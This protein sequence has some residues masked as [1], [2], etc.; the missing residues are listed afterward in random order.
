M[1]QVLEKLSNA[2]PEICRSLELS[3]GAI[4]YVKWV[5]RAE[6]AFERGFRSNLTLIS[7]YQDHF[8]GHEAQGYDSEEE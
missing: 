4:S 8:L 3:I 2:G 5:W 6:I 1:H 7:A